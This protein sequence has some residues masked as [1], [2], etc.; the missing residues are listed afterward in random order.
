MVSTV[1]LFIF[2]RD[3]FPM[4]EGFMFGKLVQDSPAAPSFLYLMMAAAYF[5][6]ASHTRHRHLRHALRDSGREYLTNAHRVVPAYGCP[7]RWTRFS[8]I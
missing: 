8:H 1:R 2:R 6:Q 3:T 5:R 4:V 7:G